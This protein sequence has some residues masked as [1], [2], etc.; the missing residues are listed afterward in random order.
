MAVPSA[1]S[2][3]FCGH[4]CDK[5][6]EASRGCTQ[7]PNVYE[8]LHIKEKPAWVQEYLQLAK[9]THRHLCLDDMRVTNSDGQVI[10]I[11][12][13]RHPCNCGGIASLQTSFAVPICG[14]LTYLSERS[15]GGSHQGG[16]ASQHLSAPSTS[17]CRCQHQ[18]RARE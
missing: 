17:S 2:T 16:H 14:P 11:K 12:D 7:T 6:T 15:R 10:S 3:P 5:T 1:A 9:I 18:D 8:G 4:F 13:S